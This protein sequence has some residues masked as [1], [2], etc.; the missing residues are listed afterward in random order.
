MSALL[1]A[2]HL[3]G[4]TLWV[5]G[6]GFAIM[7]L[8]PSLAVIE[9]A[10]RAALMAETHRRFLRIVWAMMPLVLLTG[11]AMLFG[12]LGGFRGV[13]WPVHAMHLVGLVMGGIFLVIWFGPFQAMRRAMAAGDVGAAMAANDRIRKLVSVNF[14]LGVLSL[15]LGGAAR[16]GA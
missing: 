12:V 7:A 9:P 4:A 11:Y 5:G 13:G 8:R 2:L 16:F 1:L 14:S 6:M 10:A 15:V 3:I